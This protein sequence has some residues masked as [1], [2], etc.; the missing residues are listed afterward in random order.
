VGVPEGP[1][2]GLDDGEADGVGVGTLVGKADG[3]EDGCE[4]G[5]GVGGPVGDDDGELVG[6]ELG[7][8]GKDGGRVGEHS[9][10]T[11]LGCYAHLPPRVWRWGSWW[12]CSWAAP[13]GTRW[14]V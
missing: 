4:V 11:C 14:V 12:A 6:E 3:D 9:T 8:W 1:G 10:A 5:A 13:S 2:V 7:D